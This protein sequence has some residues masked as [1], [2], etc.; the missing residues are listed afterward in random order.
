ML[1]VSILGFEDFTNQDIRNGAEM[2]RWLACR[3]LR[4][5][6]A[7]DKRAPCLRSEER[8]RAQQ[9]L[10]STMMRLLSRMSFR[11]MGRVIV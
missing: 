10:E 4:A 6:A 5:E 11:L 8:R 7:L 1:S 9:V 2:L 3:W